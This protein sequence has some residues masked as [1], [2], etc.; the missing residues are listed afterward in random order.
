MV[1]LNTQYVIKFETDNHGKLIVLDTKMNDAN[2]VLMNLN[3]PKAKKKRNEEKMLQEQLNELLAQ[4]AHCKSNPLLRT[5]IDTKHINAPQTNY[6]PKGKGGY[7]RSKAG[8]AEYGEENT[9]YL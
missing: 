6:R 1:I 4:S 3:A 2:L 7:L 9:R 8:W 5:K